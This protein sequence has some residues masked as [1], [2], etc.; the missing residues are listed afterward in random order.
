[1]KRGVQIDGA[2]LRAWR[3]ARGLSQ[4]ELAR[5]A[6]VTYVTVSRVE[7]GHPTSFGTIADLAEGLNLDSLWQLDSYPS[8]VRSPAAAVELSDSSGSSDV[9]VDLSDASGVAVMDRVASGETGEVR[10]LEDFYVEVLPKY[11]AE[12]SD[13]DLAWNVEGYERGLALALA[14]RAN[15][16]R[17]EGAEAIQGTLRRIRELVQSGG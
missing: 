8:G 7:N 12:Q 4:R 10:E 16:D 11:L 2:K 5:R 6:G 9:V 17:K 13:R 1:M 15:K 14:A 3:E